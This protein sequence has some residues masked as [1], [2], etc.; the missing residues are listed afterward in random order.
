MSKDERFIFAH[1]FCTFPLSLQLRKRSFDDVRGLFL[2]SVSLVRFLIGAPMQVGST[3][4]AYYSMTLMFFPLSISELVLYMLGMKFI[5]KS[6][7]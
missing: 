2:P 7:C 6:N 4:M 1:I 3:I 5:D